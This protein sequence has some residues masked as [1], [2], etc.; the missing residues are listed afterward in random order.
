MYITITAQKM[1]GN[2]SQSSADFVGYLEKENEGLEQRD[3]EHF[4]NQ[5]GDEISAEEVVKEIDGN[6]A[7]L[8][9]KEPKFYSI[10][11]SPSKYELRK[12]Q[13]SSQN[14]KTYTREL[15]KDYVSSFNREINGRP[16]SIDDIKYYA[17]IEHQRHFKGLDKEVKENQP[18]RAEIASLIN[19]KQ[20]VLRGE[21]K[22]NI[23]SIEKR[24]T[25]LQ[26]QTPHKINGK[27]IKEGMPKPGMQTHVH[28][29]VSRKD[30]TNSYSLS[31]GSKYKASETILNGKRVKRGFHRDVFFKNSEQTFDKMF[32]YKRNF[33]ESYD[34]RKAFRKS[35]HQYYTKLLGLPQNEKA[36]A[37][38]ILHKAGVKMP[39]NPI[40]TN[41]VQLA[42]KTINR[43]KKA[44]EIA[45]ASSTIGF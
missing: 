31:P 18:Y 28:I 14:L 13:N 22:G 1:G 34:G 24:I 9:K 29:I 40:P 15:M 33:V 41:K 10:T 45:K 43:F 5:F 36:A 30:A 19:Q 25:Q 21:Q 27:P 32:L 2:Y 23:K 44:M 4:F 11:V 6:T 26:N 8:K 12:L 39:K 37:F 17:K 42:L 3:M 38:K 7:K 35:P 16:I 20:K